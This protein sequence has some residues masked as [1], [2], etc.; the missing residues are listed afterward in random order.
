MSASSARRAEGSFLFEVFIDCLLCTCIVTA[1][2]VCV[3]LSL[4]ATGRRRGAASCLSPIWRN[5][6][7]AVLVDC[8]E[9]GDSSDGR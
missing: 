3:S 2:K 4:W 9:I 6:L 5:R 8:S 7:T 1:V